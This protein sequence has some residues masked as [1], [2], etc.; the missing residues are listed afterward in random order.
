MLILSTKCPPLCYPCIKT[1]LLHPECAYLSQHSNNIVDNKILAA[2]FEFVYELI[3]SAMA[4]LY[5]PLVAGVDAIL[6]DDRLVHF[7]KKRH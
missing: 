1:E 4:G 7:K 2:I 3:L 6:Q 5:G